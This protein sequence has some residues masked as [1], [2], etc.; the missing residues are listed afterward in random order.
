MLSPD[1]PGFVDAQRRLRS[2]FGVEVTFWGEPAEVYPPGT[3]LDPDTGRPYDPTIKPTTASAASAAVR[4][5]VAFRS[6]TENQQ[7]V[8]AIGIA[9]RTHVQLQADITDAPAIEDAI[10]FDVHSERFKV[11]AKKPDGIGPD[12]QRFLIWGRKE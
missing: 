3:A 12:A 5:T 9:D 6:N 2:E 10:A 8:G 4:C 1:L 11:E 7:E